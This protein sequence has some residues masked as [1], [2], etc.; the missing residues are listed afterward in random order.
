M[1]LKVIGVKSFVKPRVPINLLL[2]CSIGWPRTAHVLRYFTVLMSRKILS[3]FGIY[4]SIY[5]ARDIC[6]PQLMWCR[7]KIPDVNHF[8]VARSL[9]T[10]NRCSSVFDFLTIHI[11][12]VGAFLVTHCHNL[13]TDTLKLGIRERISVTICDCKEGLAL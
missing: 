13:L 3:C 6:M 12:H 9:L 2:S 7:L 10:E 4:T 1:L 5:Q 11:P 8:S